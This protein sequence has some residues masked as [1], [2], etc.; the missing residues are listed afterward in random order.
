MEDI[1]HSGEREVQRKTGED[2]I[3][4]ANSRGI[5]NAIVPGAINFIEKQ[6]MAIVS[7]V[8]TEGKVWVSVFVGDFGFT[9]VIDP[10]T[11]VFDK[12]MISS[13]KNDIFYQNIKEN[14]EVG[15][16]F[17]ELSSRRRFRING[18]STIN[19]EY[20]AMAARVKKN[21]KLRQAR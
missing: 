16:L 4:S 2:I 5:N 10:Y 21:Q 12:N 19:K 1:F 13:F 9:K 14:P 18:I 20:L 7:S 8:N 15:S 17:I 3:A 11:L 6:S